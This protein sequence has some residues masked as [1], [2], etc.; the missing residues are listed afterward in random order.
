MNDFQ[1][2]Y[3]HYRLC[4]QHQI[5]FLSLTPRS[6]PAGSLVNYYCKDPEAYRIFDNNTGI[7]HWQIQSECQFWDKQWSVS[8][9]DLGSRY[10]C[11]RKFGQSEKTCPRLRDCMPIMRNL[12][13]ILSTNAPVMKYVFILP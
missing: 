1:L 11:I 12:E 9:Q 10:T 2:I 5:P 7:L 4:I 6:L 8:S 13:Q 3:T